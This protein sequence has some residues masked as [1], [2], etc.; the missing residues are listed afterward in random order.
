MIDRLYSDK[1][2]TMPLSQLSKQAI[3]Y[4]ADG[5]PMYDFLHRSIAYKA[6]LLCRDQAARAVFLTSDCSAPKVAVG[7]L[8]VQPL[9]A[10]T[11]EQMSEGQEQLRG[12]YTGDMAAAIVRT[13]NTA[14]CIPGLQ[15][16]CAYL[17]AA[18]CHYDWL[19]SRCAG[20]ISLAEQ[21]DSR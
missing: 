16:Q 21:A 9:L 17:R 13:A 15:A 6:H 7:E 1:H 14:R 8:F 11:L 5:F 12:F 19:R 18:L 4:A 10:A 20:I 2:I 3:R